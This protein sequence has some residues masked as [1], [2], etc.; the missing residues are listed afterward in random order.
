M[1]T[2]NKIKNERTFFNE[3]FEKDT[4]ASASKY[5]V[6]TQSSRSHY[7]KCILS[8]SKGQTVLEFGCGTGSSAHMLSPYAKKIVGIDISEVGIE[9]AR[10]RAR[11]EGF[12]NID[13]LVMDA[14]QLAFPD[15]SFDLV[16]GTSILHHLDLRKS[17]GEI[18]KV[19][20]P[21][22]KAVFIE[23]LGTNPVI[24]LYRYMTPSLRTKDEH[25]FGS[26]D[27]LTF[28]EFFS[29][30]DI[31]FFHFLSLLSVPLRHMSAFE[32]ILNFLDA[33][34]RRIFDWLPFSKVFAWQ[35]VIVLEGPKSSG[36][37]NGDQ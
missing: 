35:V 2:E 17:L 21:E 31:V 7:Y 12:E 30:V 11:S 16:C 8:H 1:R 24:N 27:L 25:P 36:S 18:V 5:Y 22:G 10:Q 23:P 29:K 34:D 33:I 9:K 14:E 19:L 4:R 37:I 6:I 28:E 26:K 15:K 3:A 20:K 13:F 32:K